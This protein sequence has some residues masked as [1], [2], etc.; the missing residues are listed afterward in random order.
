MPCI[1]L[2]YSALLIANIVGN[3]DRS[4]ISPSPEGIV[5]SIP[6]I[7]K[8]LAIALGTLSSSAIA[9]FLLIKL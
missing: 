4:P 8:P 2:T 1:A 9:I 6:R 5:T 3:Y 7:L